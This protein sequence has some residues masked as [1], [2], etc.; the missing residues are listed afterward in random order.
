M[1]KSSTRKPGRAGHLELGVSRFPGA[2]RPVISRR[3]IV[4]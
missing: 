3:R 1:V 4:T 2:F